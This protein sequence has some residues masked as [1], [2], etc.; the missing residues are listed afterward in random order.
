MLRSQKI[1]IS[2]KEIITNTMLQYFQK[3]LSLPKNTPADIERYNNQIKYEDLLLTTLRI[4]HPS[5]YNSINGVS[6]SDLDHKNMNDVI[7]YVRTH[8]FDR[9]VMEA[10]RCMINIIIDIENGDGESERSRINKFISNLQQFG[11]DSVYG[12]PMKGSLRTTAT[13][14]EIKG[15]IIVVKCPR[16]PSNSTELIHELC[17]GLAGLN[18]LRGRAKNGDAAVPFFSYVL[19]AYYCSPPVISPNKNVEEWCVSGDNPV[20]YVIYEMINDAIPFIE[21]IKDQ[22]DKAINDTMLLL[23]QTA[24]GMKYASDTLGY[25]H[26][27]LHSNNILARLVSKSDML[28]ELPY[29]G[30]NIKFLSSKRIPAIIDYGMSRITAPD[31]TVLGKLDKSGAY[32]HAICSDNQVN[33]IADLH[34]LICFLLLDAVKTQKEHYVVILSLF[35]EYFYTNGV[36]LRQLLHVNERDNFIIVDNK[37]KDLDNFLLKGYETRYTFPNE[38]AQIMGWNLDGLIRHM[39]KVYYEIFGFMP[40]V[41]D[42]TE[43]D[44]CK[45]YKQTFNIQDNREGL[46]LFGSDEIL[47]D[48]ETTVE[49]LISTPHAEK[50]HTSMFNSSPRRITNNEIPTLY[51]LINSPDADFQSNL[52]IIKNNLDFVLARE[53][54]EL[55]RYCIDNINLTLLNIPNNKEY[56]DKNYLSF[57]KSILKVAKIIDNVMKLNTILNTFTDSIKYIQTD[58]MK[59]LFDKATKYISTYIIQIDQIDLGIINGYKFLSSLIFGKELTSPMDEEEINIAKNSKYYDLFYYY[60]TVKYNFDSLLRPNH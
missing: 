8:S 18:S 27:D 36:D 30:M 4:C 60:Q 3:A 10:F 39:C 34:K 6:I 20:G 52:E 19:D 32:I 33:A 55:N 13:S 29:N 26:N 38:L 16:E 22:T 35:L 9:N 40:Y 1:Q 54:V 31:G 57:E 48:L 41:T 12:F 5:G 17:V 25:T 45:L 43:K 15:D 24:V 14:H 42:E 56:L 44:V 28:I 53:R 2:R 59:A 46:P 23:I 47:L 50:E 37:D 51:S 21:L 58:D 7:N 11:A 49:K